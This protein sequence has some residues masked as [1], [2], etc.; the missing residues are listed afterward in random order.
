MTI[1][2]WVFL[3]LVGDGVLMAIMWFRMS[4]REWW[5]NVAMMA[6]AGTPIL[7][8]LMAREAWY[9]ASRLVRKVRR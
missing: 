7:V 8:G 5:D 6:L 2:P 1:A 9:W 4:Q 3:Y